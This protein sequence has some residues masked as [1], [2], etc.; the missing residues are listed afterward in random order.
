[1]TLNDRLRATRA[2]IGHIWVTPS[3]RDDYIWIVTEVGELGQELTRLLGFMD[4]VPARNHP[5]D[6]SA[7]Q[8]REEIADIVIM[9]TALAEK[10]GIV[11]DDAVQEKLNYLEK[12]FDD[13]QP[14]LL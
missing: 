13:Q 4:V 9:V 12:R 11:V 10:L 6:T 8:L 7:A 2:K 3:L 1:M 5:R 14:P